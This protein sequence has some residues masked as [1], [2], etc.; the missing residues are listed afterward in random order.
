MK[1]S[2]RDKVSLTPYMRALLLDEICRRMNII[3]YCSSILNITL[4]QNIK[5]TF[6]GA[7]PFCHDCDA[8]VINESTGKYLC[9]HCSTAGDFLTL[10][11]KKEGRNLNSSLK[12]L[13]G[14]LEKAESSKRP[15]AGGGI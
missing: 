6:I 15:Y 3:T 13:S 7:C 4:E 5:N 12:I 9:I 8:F 10:M 2:T 14:Y 11:S 1:D